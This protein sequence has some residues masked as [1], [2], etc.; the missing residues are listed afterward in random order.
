MAEP[1][2]NTSARLDFALPAA[3]SKHAGARRRGDAYAARDQNPFCPFQPGKEFLRRPW[4]RAARAR[5]TRIG[6]STHLA[7]APGVT[8]GRQ[9]KHTDL[10]N[11]CQCSA[12]RAV[13][14][15]GGESKRQ[16]QRG[17]QVHA[18]ASRAW[19]AFCTDEYKNSARQPQ[20][21]R[22][23]YHGNA[24]YTRVSRRAFERRYGPSHCC[25]SVS[26]CTLTERPQCRTTRPGHG[27]DTTSAQSASRA[28]RNRHML[29]PHSNKRQQSSR[30]ARSQ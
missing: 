21:S 7:D 23:V 26:A 1:V 5:A 8:R 20:A 18:R 15:A 12:C 28:R 11:R 24:L 27:R 9:L 16:K 6:L 10:L 29:K 13:G 17:D 19:L 22:C 3:A 30:F 14:C 2:S 4:W 25:R